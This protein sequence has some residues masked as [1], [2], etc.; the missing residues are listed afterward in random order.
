[1]FRFQG[2]FEIRSSHFEFLPSVSCAVMFTIG[3]SSDLSLHSYEF[4]LQLGGLVGASFYVSN[5]APALLPAKCT[6]I[7]ALQQLQLMM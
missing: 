1:M 5:L 4:P 3:L 6:T 2:S 7:H